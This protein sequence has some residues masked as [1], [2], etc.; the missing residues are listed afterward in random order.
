VPV[1]QSIKKRGH[2]ATKEALR[3]NVLMCLLSDTGPRRAF[4]D[5]GPLSAKVRRPRP[6]STG[7]RTRERDQLK[8]KL[9]ACCEDCMR[10]RK[11]TRLGPGWLQP[12]D[13]LDAYLD[14]FCCFIVVFACKFPSECPTPGKSGVVQSDGNWGS[15]WQKQYL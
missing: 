5:R 12:S 15:V 10:R 8:S 14:T 1:V 9:E 4:H 7:R 13:T 2:S 3:A 11:E 6:Y